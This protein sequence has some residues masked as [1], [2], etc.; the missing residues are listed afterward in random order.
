M[1]GEDGDP[2]QSSKRRSKHSFEDDS[3]YAE[4]RQSMESGNYP[5]FEPYARNRDGGSHKRHRPRS[6]G[7]FLL[8]SAFAPAQTSEN[9]H[10][11]TESSQEKQ[12]TYQINGGTDIKK[13]P[14][15]RH[16]TQKSTSL[17]SSPLAT[18]VINSTTSTANTR[19][20]ASAN[21]STRLRDSRP[22]TT[23][24][25]AGGTDGTLDGGLDHADDQQG[26]SNH[27]NHSKRFS[28]SNA[29]TLADPDPLQIVN[30]ALSLSESRRRGAD[31]ARRA[32]SSGLPVTGD[33]SNDSFIIA[34]PSGS[35]KNHV[36]QA[37]RTSK[38]SY[39][40]LSRPQYHSVAATHPNVQQPG[41]L[42]PVEFTQ[43][44]SAQPRISDATL[45]RAEKAKAAIELAVQY[46][47]LLQYVPPVKPRNENTK[48]SN[49]SSPL[50]Q[51]FSNSISRVVSASSTKEDLGR[52][53]NPLQSIR[54]RRV[55]AR[56]RKPI[57]AEAQGWT[58]L[59]RVSAWIDAVEE[60]S[61][62]PSFLAGETVDL[63][64]FSPANHGNGDV[65]LSSPVQTQ[66]GNPYKRPSRD[67]VTSPAELLADAYWLEQGSNKKQIEDRDGKRIYTAEG[68]SPSQAS[69]RSNENHHHRNNSSISGKL[70][71]FESNDQLPNLDMNTEFQGDGSLRGR[72][73]QKI[74]DT[75]RHHRS[76]SGTSR[77]G[78]RSGG[79]PAES[80]SSEA[81]RASL[82]G[83]KRHK[84]SRRVSGEVLDSKILEKQMME[85]LKREAKE[86]E[87][88]S[89]GPRSADGLDSNR[90]SS[91]NPSQTRQS[92]DP[93]DKSTTRSGRKITPDDTP[94]G[95]YPPAGDPE[96]VSK[97]KPAEENS[98]DAPVIRTS[99]EGLDV[100]APSSPHGLRSKPIADHV[101]P[102]ITLSLSAPASRETSPLRQPLSKTTT[103]LS[104]A[105]SIDRPEG[106]N[107][108]ALDFAVSEKKPLPRPMSRHNTTLSNLNS[109]V[110]S[111]RSPIKKIIARST[112]DGS[113]KDI[114]RAE[115]RRRRGDKEDGDIDAPKIRGIF[116][117]GRIEEIVRSE[118]SKVGDFIWKKEPSSLRSRQASPGSSYNSDSD[119]M[120]NDPRAGAT[121]NDI[122]RTA[123]RNKADELDGSNFQSRYFM[124]NLPS[125]KSPFAR[126]GSSKI[127]LESDHTLSQ[128]ASRDQQRSSRFERPAPPKVDVRSATP[129]SRPR[130]T[131]SSRRSAAP[132]IEKRRT[133]YAQSDR[134]RSRPD[135]ASTDSRE[136]SEI[137]T[138]QRS[139]ALGEPGEFGSRGGRNRLPVTALTALDASG[140]RSQSRGPRQS[141]HR[142]WSISDRAVS[143]TRGPTSRKE[144]ARVRALLL[145]SGVK[146]NEIQRKAREVR[147]K[148]SINLSNHLTAPLPPLPRMKQ[149]QYLAQILVHDIELSTKLFEESAKRFRSVAISD[150]FDKIAE[151]QE[152]FTSELTPLVRASADEADAFSTE[153]TT[154]HTLAIKQ[155]NDSVYTMMRRRRRRFRWVRRGGYVLLEWMLLGVM[156]F[157]W[158]IVVIVRLVR[159]TIGG[160]IGAIRWL[161][162]L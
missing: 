84:R 137:T 22:Y 30:L 96:A 92:N 155:L 58:D 148:P 107:T 159:G 106:G 126:P 62:D 156:W 13:G 111:S 102:S 37:H 122:S 125:F 120:A 77:T 87:W 140:H 138:I 39:P 116:K 91:K 18:T 55:R 110:S 113:G 99:M 95:E 160:V 29:S 121:S 1:N 145:S 133:S 143:V 46:R 80:S 108:D 88:G 153:L 105:P 4:S 59:P 124:G 28:S 9:R 93:S 35:L 64:A 98:D 7:G 49:P 142:Q 130:R 104:T 136:R 31:P 12:K 53:F 34:R 52:Q 149:H 5:S 134:S 97:A 14:I 75:F 119:D 68:L 109:E 67:W 146:A 43:D 131:D 100:T 63:P 117:G 20:I 141:P 32:A 24:P 161:F 61:K 45:A 129:S 76:K 15:H 51:T 23:H 16:R 50:S 94:R 147:T 40:D 132:R 118:V 115:S 47:R 54:N 157:A 38:P 33:L 85:M 74:Q 41:L 112:D 128:H 81:D 21:T 152:Q 70:S 82:K 151:I 11:A 8:E 44:H 101:V 127:S 89:P 154:T 25:F 26:S 36:Q 79:S 83:R 90:D 150:L 73:R 71:D 42:P 158:F 6:S 69:R 66:S 17:G 114:K 123:T 78:H 19:Q 27:V 86:M 72:R 3:T 139:D 57:N 162:W 144:I 60:R 56:D 135:E 48:R 10:D 2:G 103:N 65:K